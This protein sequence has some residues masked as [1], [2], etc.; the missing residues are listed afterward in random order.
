M[1]ASI[2]F[3]SIHTH[4]KNLDNIYKSLNAV[5]ARAYPRSPH[6]EIQKDGVHIIMRGFRAS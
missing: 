4:L 2:T 1:T 3:K 5:I 6:R